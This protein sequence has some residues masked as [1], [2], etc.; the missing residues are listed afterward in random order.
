MNT[1][2]ASISIQRTVKRMSPTDHS[3]QKS[4]LAYTL[5]RGVAIREVTREAHPR[6]RHREEVSGPDSS[7][8]WRG[9]DDFARGPYRLVES[10]LPRLQGIALCHGFA[11]QRAAVVVEHHAIE[12]SGGLARDI[13]VAHV[14]GDLGRIAPQRIAV[15]AAARGLDAHDVALGHGDVRLARLLGRGV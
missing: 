8:A 9:H 12:R 2:I 7:A 10:G 13:A 1:A 15:A 4:L 11:R 14:I 6:A 3:F 5:Q